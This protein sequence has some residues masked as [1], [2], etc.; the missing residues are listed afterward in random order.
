[1]QKYPE[2]TVGG[3]IINRRGE[4]FLM[5]SYKFRG[6][7]VIPGG[8]VEL[9]ETLKEALIREVKEE[10]GLDIY[11]I[12]FLNVQ[13]FVF[14]NLF[15]RKKHFIFLDFWCETKSEKAV[16]NS[17]GQEYRW[18]QPNEIKNLPIEPYSKRAIEEYIKKMNVKSN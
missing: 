2:P 13:E 15:W 5:K 4:I 3:V 11:N 7:Y 9:G 8:H 10:T 16:L 6:K 1:M 12:N 18:M 14:D 17:E